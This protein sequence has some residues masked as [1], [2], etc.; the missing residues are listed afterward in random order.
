MEELQNVSTNINK[1]MLEM[2]EDCTMQIL[3]DIIIDT[4]Q[5]S[6][7]V[8]NL[9]ASLFQLHP[10]IYDLNFFKNIIK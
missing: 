7:F 5:V 3:A 10:F 2:A 9:N 6:Y 4:F 8:I 1:T